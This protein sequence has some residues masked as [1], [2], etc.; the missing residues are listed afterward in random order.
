MILSIL[1]ALHIAVSLIGIVS[2]FA[3]VY[4][5]FHS[6]INQVVSRLFLVTTAVTSLSGYLFPFHGITPGQVVGILS[7]IALAIS[8]DALRRSR[9]LGV[10]QSAGQKR[11]FVI[12][13]II[14]LYLNVFVLTIQLFRKVPVL[15]ALAPTQAEPP[16]QIVQLALLIGFTVITFRAARRF[17]AAAIPNERFTSPKQLARPA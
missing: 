6:R 12:A 7:L 16:F 15:K 13:S 11:R 2:G 5:L 9:L 17:E 8:T 4:G 1:V 10:W 3:V 14:A